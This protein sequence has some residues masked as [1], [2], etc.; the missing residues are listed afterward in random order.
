MFAMR[1]ITALLLCALLAACAT[2]PGKTASRASKE[3]RN[4]AKKAKAKPRVAN[5]NPAPNVTLSQPASTLG[6]TVQHIGEEVGGSLVLMN[7]IESRKVGPLGFKSEKFG[8]VVEHLAEMTGCKCKAYPNY[9][10][11]Y[12]AGYEP[13]LDVTLAG[14]LD[15]A[16]AGRTAGMSFGSDT[17]LYEAF[18][19]LGDT[20][21]ITIVADN[22]VAEAKC[23]ALTL[24]NIPLEDGLD[25]L[26][27]SA[28][29]V[30]AAF[31]VESTAEYIFIYASQNV[32]PA[33]ALLNPE[34][35]TP[36]QNAL[37][38][39]KVDVTLP[40]PQEDPEHRRM[41]L[42]ATPLAKVLGTL[43]Q[44]IG[45]K[46]S[47]EPGLDDLPVNPCA[48]RQVRVRTA[49]DL[50]IRQWYQPEFGYRLANDQIVIER[51]K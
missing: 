39:K 8:A 3:S 32:T 31:Q 45:A 33:S 34:A 6:D 30:P 15:G 28:R 22:I 50:L 36:E 40:V 26:L 11:V 20:L 44:S 14:K 23:G 16:Y 49:M 4:E 25:A 51:R 17:P 19:L 27:Q 12:V 1:R 21:G 43:S 46:V 42:G 48:L 38:D 9:W 2:G 5:V 24:A 10:F 41:V 35:L 7:G 47:I 13:V 29:L 18:A 37:L